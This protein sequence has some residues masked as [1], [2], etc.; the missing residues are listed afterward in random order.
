M[1]VAW[2]FITYCRVRTTCLRLLYLFLKNNTVGL[3]N[4]E[5]ISNLFQADS[6]RSMAASVL[7]GLLKKELLSNKEFS[8]VVHSWQAFGPW[9]EKYINKEWEREMATANKGFT[10]PINFLEQFLH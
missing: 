1:R 4:L 6:E 9:T 8:I 10:K 2:F 7:I 3:D 5:Q